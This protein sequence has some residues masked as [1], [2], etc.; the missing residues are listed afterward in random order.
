MTAN[1][2]G[3]PDFFFW[4]FSR[5]IHWGKST[6]KRNITTGIGSESQMTISASVATLNLN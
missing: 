2:I 6:G 3:G 4:K 1:C 5:K